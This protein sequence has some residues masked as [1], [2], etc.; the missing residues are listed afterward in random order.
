MAACGNLGN[1]SEGWRQSKLSTTNV[2][3]GRTT[4]LIFLDY[5][6]NG[7]LSCCNNFGE[8]AQMMEPWNY[9]SCLGLAN[10]ASPNATWVTCFGKICRK[11]IL[12]S[13]VN[14]ASRRSLF[15][16]SKVWTTGLDNCI[17]I[18][19][20]G[21]AK[22][23]LVWLTAYCKL[24]IKPRNL[25]ISELVTGASG[26]SLLELSPP[27]SP[28]STWVPKTP[29]LFRSRSYWIPGSIYKALEDELWIEVLE[30]TYEAL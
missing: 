19:P 26:T 24:P 16:W 22:S 2:P 10:E 25:V 30:D 13:L 1:A 17:L 18:S 29:W 5:H 9:A 11:K 4:R 7:A 12:T 15:P 21:K 6:V 27:Q 23:F 20:K 3:Q 14:W 28:S 8:V